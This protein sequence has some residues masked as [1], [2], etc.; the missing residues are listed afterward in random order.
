MRRH[1][2]GYVTPAEHRVGMCGRF[3]APNAALSIRRAPDGSA[4]VSGLA[5]CANVSVCPVCSAKVRHGRAQDIQR[6]ARIHQDQGGGLAFLTLTAPHDLSMPLTACW[7]LLRRAFAD[8]VSGR[9][10]GTLRDRFGVTGYVRAVEVTRGRRGWHVHSHLLLFTDRP[11]DRMEQ[12]TE[13]WRW[14]HERWARRVVAHGGRPPSLARGVQVLPCRDD[15][16]ALA[17]YLASVNG[18]VTTELT[19]ADT[20]GARATGSRTP[21]QL[22][23]DHMEHGDPADL[24]AFREYMVG[25]KGR[26]VIEWSRGLRGRLLGTDEHPTDDDLAAEHDTAETV[27][28]LTR[29]TW[30]ALLIAR[31]EIEVLAVAPRGAHAI[32]DAIRSWGVPVWL[33]TRGR[34]GPGVLRLRHPRIA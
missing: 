17:T 10:R 11:W 4:H 24:A 3:G 34:A 30:R 27:V 20:K 12:V 9:Q 33:D 26:R 1:L 6:A 28:D 21:M 31:C 18:G 13:F 19:R 29:E 16:D 7:D 23:H 22:L 15:N 25:A 14:V 5:T 8:I 32:L 2:Q